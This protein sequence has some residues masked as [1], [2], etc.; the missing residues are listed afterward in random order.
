MSLT[1]EQKALLRRAGA[2]FPLLFVLL[3]LLAFYI[4]PISRM[5][6]LSIFDPGFT[7]E[8]FVHIFQTPL[9][10]ERLAFTFR[11]SLVV[12]ITCIALGFPVAFLMSTASS[13][14]RNLVVIMVISPLWISILVRTFAWMALLGREGLVNRFLLGMGLISSPL[15][16]MHNFFGVYV[17]MVHVLLPYAILPMF[18]VMAGIDRDLL[19]AAANL[20]ANPFRSFMRIFFPLSLP[21]VAGSGLLTFMMSLG[22]Y[23][24]P[25]LLGGPSEIMI[26]NVIDVQITTG[27]NWGFGSALSVILLG[28]SLMIIAIYNRF[29]GLD[30]LLGGMA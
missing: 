10:F 20:G 23:V 11:L 8:H 30:Q 15:K 16:L 6:L 17:G 3:Y 21:G 14:V 29:L 28:S 1:P 7:L 2:Y 19:K 25:L 22:F 4:Y 5:L 13:L 9:Y 24:T 18:S 27:L 12:T 26:A